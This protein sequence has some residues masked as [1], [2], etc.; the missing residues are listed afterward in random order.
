[1]RA[2]SSRAETFEPLKKGCGVWP[3]EEIGQ[4][5]EGLPRVGCWFGPAWFRASGLE[6]QGSK[7]SKCFKPRLNP[8]QQLP[9][10][11]FLCL[12][13]LPRPQNRPSRAK[14]A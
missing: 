11:L 1:V 5:G 2:N 13:L 3:V 12:N 14:R 9:Q 10:K 4:A 8:F 7:S 6:N